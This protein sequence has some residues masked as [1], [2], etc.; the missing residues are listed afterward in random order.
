MANIIDC[1]FNSAW[2]GESVVIS[3]DAKID[4]DTGRI[5]DIEEV[6]GVGDDGVEVETLDREYVDFVGVNG[7]FEVE[8]GDSDDYVVCDLGEIVMALQTAESAKTLKF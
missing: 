3:T 4:L 8:R 2:D 5:F 1:T 7:E 6:E